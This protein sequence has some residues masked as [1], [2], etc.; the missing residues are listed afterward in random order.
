[1][2][3]KPRSWRRRLRDYLVSLMYERTHN[4]LSLRQAIAWKICQW[5]SDANRHVKWPVHPSSII[6]H[7]ERIK[8]GLGTRPGYSSGCYIQ[9]VN[10]IEFGD[11]V[12]VAPCVAII[13]ANHD[14]DRNMEHIPGPPIKIG[15][16]TWLCTHCVI[17]PGVEL[18]ESV[19]V[20]AGAVVTKSFPSRVL[21][22][23]VPAKIV[24][25]LDAD[26]NPPP[27]EE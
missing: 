25:Y 24:R 22:A 26:V 23:G 13:S 20:A 11:R 15:S 10:G 27:E 16:R 19:V 7:P 1:M 9:A 4:S 5:L 8:L 18:G 3:A 21:V 17:L 6:V 12:G 14:I 2:N